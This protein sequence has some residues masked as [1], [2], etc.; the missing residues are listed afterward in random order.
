MLI[1]ALGL[2]CFAH[3][4]RGCLVKRDASQLGSPERVMTKNNLQRVI[5][6]LGTN[7]I[8]IPEITRNGKAKVEKA[9]LTKHPLCTPRFIHVISF[10]LRDSEEVLLCPPYR[11]I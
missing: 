1:A 2:T 5:P 8:V 10:S 6:L 7:E 11:H 9:R 4:N 3:T